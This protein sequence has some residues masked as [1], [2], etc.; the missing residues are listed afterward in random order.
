MPRI[1]YMFVPGGDPGHTRPVHMFDL[2]E[3]QT[4]LLHKYHPNAEMWMSP[5]SFNAEWME[6][7]YGLMD[8]EPD[9]LGGN[10][11]RTPAARQPAGT[12]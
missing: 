11:F 5:Q 4:T 1:D 9:W 2:L 6:E 3:Q 8:K 7:F 12:A 10:R